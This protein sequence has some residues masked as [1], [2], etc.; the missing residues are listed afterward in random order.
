MR[1]GGGYRAILTSTV[2][3]DGGAIAFQINDEHVHTLEDASLRGTG[4]G[5]VAAGIG[6][7]E[8]DDFTI[9]LQGAP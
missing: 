3:P 8:Y 5:I 9:A 7:F 2:G 1:G 4:V 6:R